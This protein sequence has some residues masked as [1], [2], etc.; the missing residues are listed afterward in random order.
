MNTS[1]QSFDLSSICKRTLTPYRFLGF[2]EGDGTFSISNLVP[3][4]AIKQ[5]TKNV[6]FFYE[7]SG[8]LT[9]LPYNPK[10]GPAQDESENTKP[11]PGV[12]DA[13]SNP[14]TSSMSI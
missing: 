8:F 2:V 9:D 11:Y 10:I 4:F 1:R 13:K 7:V 14:K 12:Y 5:H 6:H 3:I